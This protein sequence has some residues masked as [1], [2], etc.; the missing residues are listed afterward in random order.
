VGG[1]FRVVGKDHFLRKGWGG[2]FKDMDNNSNTFFSP[3]PLSIGNHIVTINKP[4]I[5]GI[6]NITPDSFSDGGLYL[7]HNKAFEHAL[8]LEKDG[9]DIID[10]GGESTR[11]GA[12]PISL[13]EEENRILPVIQEIRKK[14]NIPISVDTTKAE[15]AKKAIMLGANMINDISAGTFDPDMFKVAAKAEVPICIMHIKGNPKHMQDNPTYAD[16]I[17][18]IKD[19]FKTAINRATLAGIS[20]DKLI[21][22]PGIGFGKTAEDN[23]KILQNISKFRIFNKHILIGTSNKS[24]IGAML[25]LNVKERLEPTLATILYAFQQGT[26]I[27]RVHDVLATKKFLSMVEILE[28]S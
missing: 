27:F 11:P 3:P 15:I 12:N 24:F 20:P 5:M 23:I 4:T 21:I 17:E 1:K 18:E 2:R 22:D 8:K 14:S 26:S 6:V 7:D 25:N 19:Y 28:K 13:N 16:I 10:I 9:A